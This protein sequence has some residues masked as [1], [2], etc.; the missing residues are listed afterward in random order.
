MYMYVYMNTI[1]PTGSSR[2]EFVYSVWTGFHFLS[3]SARKRGSFVHKS[4][5]WGK[6]VQLVKFSLQEAILWRS[7]IEHFP[8]Q[9]FIPS[10]ASPQQWL[11]GTQ[12]AEWR[13]QM[14][15]ERS[16]A[17]QSTA[18]TLLTWRYE[19]L[20]LSVYN[21]IE[22]NIRSCCEQAICRCFMVYTTCS[23]DLW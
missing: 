9:E 4:R 8:K 12:Y 16:H 13:D 23:I 3:T 21:N 22:V 19:A 2:S 14:L 18:S 6:S 1:T 11:D 5:G 17:N 20:C 15:L 10:I 7:K